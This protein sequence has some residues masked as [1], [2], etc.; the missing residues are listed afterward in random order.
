MEYTKKHI[1]Y[2]F[3]HFFAIKAIFLRKICYIQ[4]I[5]MNYTLKTDEMN[6]L[7]ELLFHVLD[8]RVTF[9]DLQEQELNSFTIKDMSIFCKEKRSDAEFNDKCIECDRQHIELAKKSREI[10]IYRC[11]AGL[12]EGIV[13]IYNKNDVYLG[14]IFYGQLP[15][16][17]API[18][19][20]RSVS[21][22]EMLHVGN[23]LKY[24]G[25]YISENELIRKSNQPWAAK[26]EE[27]IENHLCENITLPRL[28]AKLGCSVSY[29][30]HRI[31]AEFG[32]P[33]KKFIRRKRMLRAISL[34]Q[35]GRSVGECAELLGYKN[36]F[37]FSS[38]FKKF[39]NCAPL[40]WLRKNKT[41]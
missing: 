41:R 22:T 40:H 27:Y 24:L 14:S 13:P 21:K 18:E 33:L 11:H 30:S 10:Q 19:N 39:H 32:M 1:L 15:D 38:D 31:P 3:W 7:M 20:L 36:Q 16:E 34:L 5:M 9:F 23:L 35:N 17:S 6:K 2:I 28:A 4:S 25:E 8:M 29:L 12:W 37:Y 26:L